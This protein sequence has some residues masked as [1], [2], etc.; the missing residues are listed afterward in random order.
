MDE[1]YR[2]YFTIIVLKSSLNYQ[3]KLYFLIHLQNF[4]NVDYLMEFKELPKFSSCNH[5][6]LIF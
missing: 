2:S 5:E 1:I 4:G 3:S 6:M